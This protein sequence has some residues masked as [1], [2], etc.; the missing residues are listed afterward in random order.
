MRLAILLGFPVK[1][2]KLIH[3]IL[4]GMEFILLILLHITPS[5]LSMCLSLQRRR[6]FYFEDCISRINDRVLTV[7][8]VGLDTVEHQDAITML[9]ECGNQVELVVKRKLL[10]PNP[11]DAQPTKVVLQKRNK[12]DGM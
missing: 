6:R 9:K 8:G 12:R 11:L 4:P 2:V 5:F 7:N 10:V 1:N 3:G